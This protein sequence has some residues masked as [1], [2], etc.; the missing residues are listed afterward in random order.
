MRLIISDI[1]QDGLYQEADLQIAV[2][3]DAEKENAHVS[4]NVHKF[5]KR[6]LIK[7]SAGMSSLFMC[8]RCLKQFYLL[9]SADF[10]EEYL[11]APEVS[12]AVEQELTAEEIDSGFYSGD[13]INIEDLIREQLLLAV[14]MKPLCKPDC[15]G[16]CPK[17]GKDLNDGPCGCK[18]D[19]IDSRLMPLKKIKESFKYRKE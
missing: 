13:E 2:R 10:E 9:L 7:G 4:I 14:P 16:I 17:C 8:S 1:P 5:G 18:E 15:R 11:P 6:V 12:G 3:E 19:E